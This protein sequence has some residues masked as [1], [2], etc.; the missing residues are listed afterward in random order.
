[1]E[2]I[3]NFQ[4]E[5]NETLYQAWES[6]KE[7]LLRCPQHYLT[8]MHEVIS[9]YKGLDVPTRQI[10]DSKG[11]IPSMK[12]ADAKKAIQVMDDHSQ[13]WHN[14]M[15]TR[16]KSTDTSDG[17]ATIQAQLNNLEREIKKV[18]ERV[19]AAQVGL[20]GPN[21]ENGRKF[22][23]GFDKNVGR[24]GGNGRRCG[25]IAGKGGG[26]LAK[27]SM[28]SK[29]GL[30]GGG[31][32][33]LGRRSSIGAGG[34]EVKGGGDDFRVGRIFL[35]EIPRVIIGEAL[36]KHLETI[37]E[38]IDNQSNDWIYLESSSKPLGLIDL[39]WSGFV[40]VKIRNSNLNVPHY[41]VSGFAGSVRRRDVT[42]VN[43]QGQTDTRLN[44]P[45][46]VLTIKGNHDKG[47]NGNQARNCAFDIGTAEAQQDPNIMTKDLSSLPPSREVEFRI[48]LIPRVMLV[49]KLP[50]RLAPTDIQELSIQLMELQDKGFIR[51]S[52]LPCGALVLFVKKKDGSRYF[53]N[54][55]LRSGYHQLRVREE[56]IPKTASGR[57]QRGSLSSPE[58]DIGV[59]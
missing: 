49:A 29:D 26:S 33:V 1:M 15:S 28:V 23:V 4:Q 38:P 55:D 35:G 57:V 5:L 16:T 10:L 25:S 40:V 52:S 3:N 2:E 58:A 8:D 19:Y 45:N 31:F 43:F 47:N 42:S 12:A 22:K 13:I 11:A 56:D 54:I 32:V 46:P 18:N 7:L 39:I 9:F 59:A 36:V 48:D 24:C 27:H 51:P 37:E 41:S 21:G 53:S 50:Y 6:F 17:I 14:G 44:C 30:G 34:G 20:L